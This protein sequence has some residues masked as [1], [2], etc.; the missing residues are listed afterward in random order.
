MPDETRKSLVEL[1][2]RE[3]GAEKAAK[4]IQ[5]IQ[6]TA[7]TLDK[8][9][10]AIGRGR[11]LDALVKDF[12]EV[13][14]AGGDSEEAVKRLNRELTKLGASEDEIRK[15]AR[16]IGETG[17]GAGGSSG[18]GGNAPAAA[19][20]R[21][22]ASLIGGGEIVGLIDDLQDLGEG[23]GELK[24]AAP[25]AVDGLLKLAGSMGPGGLLLAGGAAVA[26]GVLA[27][28][29]KGAGDA[30]Q[31]NAEIID[32]TIESRRK[33]DQSVREGM[34]TEEAIQAQKDL[35]AAR[36][37]EIA[38]IEDMKREL[39]V[40][41]NER[42]KTSGATA[43][44]GKEEEAIYQQLLKSQDILSG[45]DADLNAL[46]IR[47][48][49]S[50]FAA[51]DAAT[52]EQELAEVRQTETPKAI[53]TAANAERDRA[54][55]ME[56][57][58]REQERKQAEI[59]RQQEQALREAEQRAEK[60]RSAQENYSKA[61]K[62]ATTDYTNAVADIGKKRREGEFDIRIA[63]GRDLDDIQLKNTQDVTKLI[64]DDWRSARDEALQNA[65]EIDDIRREG[66]KSVSE[67]YRDGDFK[68]AFLAKEAAAERIREEERTDQREEALRKTHLADMKDDLKTSLK[69]EQDARRTASIRSFEDLK[70]N[71]QR[72]LDTA[73]T[74]RQ[75]ANAL[76]QEARNSDFAQLQGHLQ[77]VSGLYAQH[78]A[79]I[80]G[81]LTAQGRGARPG[82]QRP[83]LAGGLSGGSPVATIARIMGR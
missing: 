25:G 76:A 37:D 4:E 61:I 82:G 73:A 60:A 24:S 69:Q 16:A 18:G 19:K 29:I 2:V 62:S 39:G 49:D 10:T 53:E 45:Y 13:T 63:Q 15:T 79:G 43:Q 58:A 30:A 9:L 36:D 12:K 38:L 33:F 22:A 44:R 83:A 77:R 28:A 5:G 65:N 64:T 54:R 6:K 32:A 14:E 42:I 35:Q 1:E 26:L 71:T 57:V 46:N 27:L 34:T 72:E 41:A 48:E 11:Q 40:L 68:Q 47:I 51:N 80:E 8:E 70:L 56:K 59:Q 75:R 23:L 7:E 81:M 55:E 31:K 17:S 67:A 66:L 52:K 20:F 74:A 3:K 50:A 21:G 78:F